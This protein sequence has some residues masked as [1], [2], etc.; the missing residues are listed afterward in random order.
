VEQ[1]QE[2]A[3]LETNDKSLAVTSEMKEVIRSV[4]FPDST[5]AEL[6]FFIYYCQTRGVH[7][8]SKL[9]HPVKRQGKL[10][11]Q[12][13]IDY[14]RSESE[15]AGDYLGMKQPV[16]EY[17]VDGT[18]DSATVTVLRQ[19]NGQPVEF[20]ATAYFEEYKPAPPNDF[21]WKKMPKHMI[22]KCAEALA[23]RMAWPKKLG[24]LYVP[25]EMQQ[26]D[27]DPKAAAK[28]RTSSVKPAPPAGKVI[29]A[30]QEETGTVE[31]NPLDKE[32]ME[33]LA[34]LTGGVYEEMEAMLR[35]A[36]HYTDKATKKE[37]E[38]GLDRLTAT[39]AAWKTKTVIP[40]LRK[41]KGEVDALKTE[42]AEGNKERP[43][44]DGLPGED[45]PQLPI[46]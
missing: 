2:M 21:M 40:R 17:N 41:M 37:F 13:S 11:L 22:A 18:L 45:H 9:I 27:V 16:F 38:F 46:E 39:S 10:S 1:K 36:S 32:I 8:V 25:E 26:A 15:D 6:D 3:I 7:P 43:L 24:Q 35:K 4:I 23:R 14:L 42:I 33:T 30:E 44:G 28:N 29:D 19:I 34:A 12:S 20:T 5:D 31:E